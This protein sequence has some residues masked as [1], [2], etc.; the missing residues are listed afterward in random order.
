M[1]A[2]EDERVGNQPYHSNWAQLTLHPGETPRNSPAPIGP[3]TREDN[4]REALGVSGIGAKA[5]TGKLLVSLHGMLKSNTPFNP[6][7]FMNPSP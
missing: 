1:F 6:D 7:K 2:G 3:E 5:L 4:R